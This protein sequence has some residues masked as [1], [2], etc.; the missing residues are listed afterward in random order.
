MNIKVLILAGLALV[1]QSCN[2]PK[3]TWENYDVAQSETLI[4]LYSKIVTSGTIEFLRYDNGYYQLSVYAYRL[5]MKNHKS[6]CTFYG[7]TQ[8]TADELIKIG[9]SKNWMKSSVFKQGEN[10]DPYFRCFSEDFLELSNDEK[11]KV[12]NRI[13]D[14]EQYRL[15][16]YFKDIPDELLSKLGEMGK[17]T[18]SALNDYESKYLDFIFKLDTDSFS[19]AGKKVGFLGSKKAFF[20]D[21]RER[22]L[23]GEDGVGGCGLYIFNATQK[24]E[25]GGYDA[26]IMYWSKFILPIEKVIERLKK[27]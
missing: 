8:Y 17:D 5:D 16:H 6:F 12:L 27:K 24:E 26:A 4:S 1:L 21:E 3:V 25:S 19:L 2:T 9:R 20:K 22:F 10:L 18:S 23:R 14:R 13:S 7:K 11:I 15:V